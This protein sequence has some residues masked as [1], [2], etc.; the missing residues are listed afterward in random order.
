MFKKYWEYTLNQTFTLLLEYVTAF[1][2]LFLPII[3]D[4]NAKEFPIEVVG[5]TFHP[6]LLQPL[7]ILR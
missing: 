4:L 5:I 1:Y 3:I 6:L 7:P 2:F